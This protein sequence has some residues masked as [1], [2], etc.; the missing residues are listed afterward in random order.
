MPISL[1]LDR[2]RDNLNTDPE[3]LR[4]DEDVQSVTHS[5]S[6]P[7]IQ[8]RTAA[9]LITF[10]V[11]LVRLT[12]K[13][14]TLYKINSLMTMLIT[15]LVLYGL[16]DSLAQGLAQMNPKLVWSERD[17]E[18]AEEEEEADGFEMFLRDGES[19]TVGEWVHAERQS[20][21]LRRLCWFM[22]WG[23]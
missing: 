2:N 11:L 18:R 20:F 22:V 10:L 23:E 7:R 1:P 15:N 13:Y 9:F 21:N 8:K 14:N 17:I 3:N 4:D 19:N 16:A 6:K 5:R 12:T